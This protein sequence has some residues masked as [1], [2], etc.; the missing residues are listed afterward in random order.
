MPISSTFSRSVDPAALHDLD[1]WS[2]IIQCACNWRTATAVWLVLSLA[3]DLAGLE[4][5]AEAVRQLQP[6]ALRRRLI[7][8]F[9]N[10]ETLVEM[11]DLSS[12]QSGDSPYL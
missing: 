11:R 4:E 3:V 8:R 1:V 10:A 5:A 9:A 2:V 6:S 12:S 7:H